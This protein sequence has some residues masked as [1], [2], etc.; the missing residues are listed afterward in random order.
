M[1]NVKSAQDFLRESAWERGNVK[2]QVTERLPLELPALVTDKIIEL[3]EPDLLD[4]RNINFLEMVELRA[5]VR[6]YSDKPLALKE[7]SYLLWCTQGV[8]MANDKAT[9]RT[10]PSAGATHSL[11]TYILVNNVEKLEAGVYRFLPIEH[12]LVKIKADKTVISNCFSTYQVVL[13]SAV[14]FIWSTVIKRVASRYASR[15][16]RYAFLDAGH[17]CQNLYLAAQTIS[18]GVC[19]LGSFD[20]KQINKAL[21][22]LPKEQFVVYGA[23]LGKV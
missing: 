2:P 16:Y 17:V 19:A 12:A 1:D 9:L 20:D 23:A 8:K 21:D 18:A 15:G 6:H 10:V 22:F 11:E 5:S 13:G 4:D 14:T 7:L 3:P